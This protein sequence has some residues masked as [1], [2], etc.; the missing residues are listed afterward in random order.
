M[1]GAVDVSA[2]GERLP[3]E[4]A[5][6]LTPASLHSGRVGWGLVLGGPEAPTAPVRVGVGEGLTQGAQPLR[7][8]RWPA[9]LR[10]R[11][12]SQS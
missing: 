6:A 9:A 7:A 3:A 12:R 5:G 1:P 2:V 4:L 8:L 10:P 11:R